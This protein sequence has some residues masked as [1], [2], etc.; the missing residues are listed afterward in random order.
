MPKKSCGC[1]V[2]CGDEPKTLLV[3]TAYS[4]H[5][6]WPK[7]RQR[8]GESE[9]EC[10]LRETR[11]ETGIENLVIVNGFQHEFTYTKKDVPKDESRIGKKLLVYI[12]LTPA[13]VK[14]SFNPQEIEAAKWVSLEKA[15]DAI[16]R[17]S[18]K[19]G[20]TLAVRHMMRNYY[21]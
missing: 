4:G 3:R 6:M 2:M 15:V 9:P 20:M 19:Y 21:A 5:W 7:G 16:T 12:A 1:I 18:A 11:E 10:A 17:P 8:K 14:P 13:L